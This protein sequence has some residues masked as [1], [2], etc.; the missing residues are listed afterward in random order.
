[1]AHTVGSFTLLI[2]ALQLP[3][4]FAKGEVI[5]RLK[6]G[7]DSRRSRSASAS[8]ASGFRETSERRRTISWL[9]TRGSGSRR[10]WSPMAITAS[11]SPT[12]A[13]RSDGV[14][15]S[16]PRRILIGAY[17]DPVAGTVGAD[18]NASAAAVQP[19]HILDRKRPFFRLQANK[20]RGVRI[21]KL[22]TWR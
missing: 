9:S 22:I 5:L 19:T 15:P 6:G 14:P 3:C 20:K 1:M 12:S 2:Q 8:A 4:V 16:P 17:Y 21:V 7:T 10:I 13:W 18:D 11:R